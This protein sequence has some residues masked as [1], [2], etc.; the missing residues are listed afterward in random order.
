MR[1][2]P[3]ATANRNVPADVLL[4]AETEAM[5]GEIVTTYYADREGFLWKVIDWNGHRPEP[6]YLPEL[7]RLTGLSPALL[8]GEWSSWK[9]NVLHEAA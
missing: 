2:L 5:S 8:T 1:T 6:V 3:T 9:R 7:W 4:L